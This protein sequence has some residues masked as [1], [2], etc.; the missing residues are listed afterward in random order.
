MQK[1]YL[2]CAFVISAAIFS[3]VAL[4]GSLIESRDKFNSIIGYTTEQVLA[5]IGKPD[6]RVDGRLGEVWRY[7]SVSVPW[8]D[9]RTRNPQ[10]HFRAGYVNLIL[11]FKPE[12]MQR[13]I[14]KDRKDQK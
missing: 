6:Q 1:Y 5:E 13:W 12:T 8:E 11:W 2:F 3:A 9:G 4:A 14:D 10:I 7:S